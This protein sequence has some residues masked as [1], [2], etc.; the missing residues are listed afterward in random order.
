MELISDQGL[1]VDGRRTKELRKVH[2]KLGIYG[3]ADGSAFLQQGNTK[4][5]ATVYGPH[6]PRQVFKSRV[7][8]DSALVVCD[9]SLSAFSSGDRRKR[10]HSDRKTT[11]L[12]I[13]L[14]KALTSAI[15]TELYPRT[16]IDIIVQ[17]LE[18]DGG[19]FATSINAA[20]L[21]LVNSGIAMKEYVVCC[22]A[23]LGNGNVPM[24]DITHLEETLG[25][26]TLTVAMMPHSKQIAL[27]DL[28]DR[29]H[30]DY[31][32]DVMSLAQK[33]CD[34]IYKILDNEVR[35]HMIETGSASNWGR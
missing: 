32:E 13:N 6:E 33:G 30:V 20:T 15:K 31:L 17:V 21:A 23:S 3:H 1:R 4:V 5:I 16:Q 9:Y 12:T 28:S 24:L 2:C 34:E 8:H 14:Q 10:L 29:F 27:L 26:S 35:L 22:T 11:D 18:A 7:P 19:N 25:G